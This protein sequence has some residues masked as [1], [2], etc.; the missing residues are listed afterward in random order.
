MD[1]LTPGTVVDGL[2]ASGSVTVVATKWYGNDAVH[3]TY[4]AEDGEPDHQLLYRDAEPRLTIRKASAAYSF[5]ADGSLFK[6]AAEA[7]RIR[8]AARFD[9]MLAVTTSDLEPLPHQIQAVYGEL[10]DRSPLRFVLADD[11]GAGKTIMAGLY[12]KELMLRGDLERCLVVTPGGLVDQWQEELLDKFGLRFD[13]LTRDLINAQLDQTVFEKYPLLIARM[14]QL[15]R[16][17]DLQAQLAESD[18]DLVVVD[19]AHRMS[20]NYF[21]DEL[22][23]TKRYMLGELLGKHTRNLLLMTATPHAGN[24]AGFQLFMGLLDSDRF[25]GRYREGISSTDTDG[26]MR[27]MVKEDLLTFEGKPLFPE[28]R[29]YTLPYRLS[30]PEREL[31]DVV[32]EYVREQMGRAQAMADGKRGNTVGFALTVL[33]RRLASSPEAILKS[34]AR[35]HKRLQALR[36]E[37]AAG[38]SPVETALR[39]RLARLLGKDLEDY[40]SGDLPAAELEDLENDV[41]DAA[42]A[43]QTI[44]ELDKE[45]AILADLVEVA[46]RV[47]H[48]GTD[49]KWTELRELLLSNPMVNDGAGSPRKLIIFTEHKDTLEYLRDQISGLLGSQDAVVTIHG[50]VSRDNRRKIKELFT[51][52][53]DCRILIATDAAGEG[54]NLQRANLMVNYDLPWNPNRIEQRFG[55]IH[56]IGQTEVCHLWNLVAEDTREGAVFIRLL[57]KIDEQR[58]AY[59]GKVFDVLGEA[60][61]DR[62]LRSVLMEAIQYGDR[63]DVRDRLNHVIDSSVGEGLEKL[64]AERALAHQKLAEA[65]VAEWRLRMEEA[66]ARRLQPHYIKA[67]F[68]AAFK[69]LG[70]RIGEREPG[71][72]EIS[73]VPADL[74]EYESLIKHSAPVLRRYE[75]VTFDRE[76]VRPAGAPS[77]DLLAPGHPLLDAVVSLIID[78]YGGQ[79]KQGAI[80][81]DRRDVGEEPRL[82]VAV[83]QEITTSHQPPSVVSKRFD[84][85]ELGEARNRMAGAAPYLDYAPADAEERELTAPVLE[86]PWL[87]SGVEDLAIGWSVQNGLNAHM[88]EL[89]ERVERETDRTR[90][91]VHARLLQE[92]NYWDYRYADLQEAEAAGKSTKLKSDFAARQARNLERR[93]NQRMEELDRDRRLQAR[94]P[95]VAGAALVIPQGL[96]DRLAGLREQ[97]PE[98]YARETAAVERRALDLVLAAERKLGRIPEEMAHN[99]PGYDIRSRTVDEH[100][101]FIEVKGR[102]VGAEDFHVTRTEVLTGKNSGP[103]FRLALVS[104]HPHGPDNDDVRYVVDPFKDVDF[105]SFDATEIGGNWKKTWNRGGVPV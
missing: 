82:L 94:P 24:E 33:Q 16:N 68:I 64:L 41:V 60:F 58:K 46:R 77:A 83:A 54:L 74:R 44:A 2:A 84:F 89:R 102:V 88:T 6:L 48:A 63:P 91:L 105:G 56:R 10:L 97:P 35:R 34:L 62:P 81:V 31:Y 78:R 72:Y 47:R 51:Q 19:E 42:T 59:K 85:V 53:R 20:A 39:E 29:A 12:I 37:M 55:R 50:G 87:S 71:R 49:R 103:N 4:Q 65:D 30:D 93:L 15:S 8:M 25:E 70:G 32:T 9:P 7:L 28:R 90:K 66:R 57:E 95:R 76:L 11:P 73:H 43:A 38:R 26:L 80:L 79:L 45:I 101:V 23:K 92:I 61:I 96:L 52:D 69:L 40:D 75:R 14:D 21:G 13:V 86:Q 17:E 100:W 1:D 5:D 67:F 98:A 22:K 18:W 104:V 3:V 99:N 27:R 36:Q